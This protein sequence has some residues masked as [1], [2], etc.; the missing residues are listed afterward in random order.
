[1]KHLLFKVKGTTYFIFKNFYIFGF[2]DPRI[3]DFFSGVF[4]EQILMKFL[5]N[6]TLWRHYFFIKIYFLKKYLSV[7]ESYYKIFII[8][9]NSNRAMWIVNSIF[10]F[11]SNLLFKITKSFKTDSYMLYYQLSYYV[12]LLYQYQISIYVL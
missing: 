9:S 3:Q 2:R 6:S 4:Y 8:L 1:M 7:Y 12:C 11:I 10:L 5:W